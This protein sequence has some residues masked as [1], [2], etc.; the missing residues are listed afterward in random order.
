VDDNYETALCEQCVREL[1]A[2][3]EKVEW[4]D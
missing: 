3:G 2:I 4:L 1:R